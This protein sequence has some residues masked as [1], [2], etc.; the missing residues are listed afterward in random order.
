MRSSTCDTLYP[1]LSPARASLARI[2]LG[3][4]PS[5]HRLRGGR[6]RFV[7]RVPSYYG[8]GL[9]LAT[10]HHRLRLLPFPM[11]TGGNCRT[12]GP[13]VAPVPRQGPP[14]TPRSS[15]TPGR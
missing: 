3:L 11:R 1:A 4:C 10:A 14:H 9:L 12:V 13:G 6:D 7:R 8:R 2:P 15:T 5:L